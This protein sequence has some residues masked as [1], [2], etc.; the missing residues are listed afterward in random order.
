M[1]TFV[2]L[3]Q[4]DGTDQGTPLAV[5]PNS[6]RYVLPHVDCGTQINFDTADHHVFVKEPFDK[7]I[8]ELDASLSR[9]R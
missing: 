9:T 2:K 3:T 1:S 6:V 7:V 8:R 5:N 4:V